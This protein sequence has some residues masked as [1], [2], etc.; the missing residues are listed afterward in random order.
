MIVELGLFSLV[1]ALL[2][3]VAQSFF[4]IV[5]PMRGN[6]R[7]MAAAR[8]AV[9]G[10]WVFVT[11]SFAALSWA[12]YQNDFSVLYVANNSNSELPPLYMFAA[13]WV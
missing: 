2:L 8:P 3:A 1:L 6:R 5:G 9:A 10:Q 12:F 13:V 7:W 4:G 11:L